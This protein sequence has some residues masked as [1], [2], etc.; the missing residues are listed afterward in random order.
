MVQV[1]DNM[2]EIKPI[3]MP[4]T[5]QKF[6]DFFQGKSEPVSLKVLDLGSGHGAFAS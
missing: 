2:E 6:L 1:D 3:T 5:H 4:G